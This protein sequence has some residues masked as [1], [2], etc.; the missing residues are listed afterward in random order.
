LLRCL[1]VLGLSRS[2]LIL[3]L[4]LLVLRL[5]R[6]LL[7][8]LLGRSK[9][10]VI[11]G[12]LGISSLAAAFIGRLAFR[13]ILLG[14]NDIGG[15]TLISVFVGVASVAKLSHDGDHHT[16]SEILSGELTTVAEGNDVE[17]VCIRFSIPLV[18]TIY[19][20]RITADSGSAGSLRISGFRITG[21]SAH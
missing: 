19:S 10:T 6:R 3:R 13:K 1:L 5:C 15:I 11:L 14:N 4:G 7:I 18:G 21:E 17:E 8:R 2:L 20:Q 12:S 16:L 9:I